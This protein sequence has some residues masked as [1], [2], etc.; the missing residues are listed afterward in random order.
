[1]PA[2]TLKWTC[3]LCLCRKRLSQ[4]LQVNSRTPECTRACRRRCS[5]LANLA[6]HSSHANLRSPPCDIMWT[7]SSDDQKNFLPQTA[8]AWLRSPEWT[9]SCRRRCCNAA[10]V[11]SQNPHVKRVRGL[12][13]DACVRM[14]ILRCVDSTNA[15]S[16]S[17]QRKGRSPVCIRMW[18]LR[19]L[20]LIKRLS[21]TAQIKGLSPVCIRM[22]LFKLDGFLNRRSHTSQVSARSAVSARPSAPRRPAYDWLQSLIS[23][24]VNGTLESSRV[25]KCWL[26]WT[27]ESPGWSRLLADVSSWRPLS[28]SDLTQS[29]SADNKLRSS[30]KLSSSSSLITHEAAQI[31]H[32]RWR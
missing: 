1:M 14:W 5:F 6:S 10:Y 23:G 28:L 22:W 2:W 7:F 13:C 9:R 27:L 18:V 32:L 21:H 31:Q 20:P 26:A 24:S 29:G 15:F 3:R 12:S 19:L 17:W 30:V 11:L 4:T 25:G 8:H 16:Q